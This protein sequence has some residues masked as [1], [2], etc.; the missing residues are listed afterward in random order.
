MSAR[1]SVEEALGAW[2]KPR[3]DG[4]SVIVPTMCLYPSNAVVNV[5]VD[6]GDREFVVH[7][8]GGAIEQFHATLGM[9]P[10]PKTLIYGSA[11]QRGVT[12]GKDGSL[13]IGRVGLDG[14]AGAIALVASASVDVAY[15][16]ID[17]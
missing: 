10:V 3:F 13:S 7:D 4:E 2:P 17:Y 1:I 14:L 16:L 11:R 8:G 12:V 6:G 15:H 9:E 5:Y